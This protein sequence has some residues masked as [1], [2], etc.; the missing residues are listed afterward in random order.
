MV[1]QRHGMLQTSGL[2]LE[3]RDT[4]PAPAPPPTTAGAVGQLA[5]ASSSTLATRARP[6]ANDAEASHGAS[7]TQH[8][9]D[10]RL[11][12]QHEFAFARRAVTVA[13]AE[14]TQKE[15][16][17]GFRAVSWQALTKPGA[18]TSFRKDVGE[19]QLQL[20]PIVTVLISQACSGAGSGG[21]GGGGGASPAG[22]VQER[23]PQ[24]APTGLSFGLWC[25]T[26]RLQLNMGGQST[27]CW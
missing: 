26:T 17:L 25:A 20:S 16:P 22:T 24:S 21:G 13:P 4:G 5:A 12:H 10:R 1:T 11:S 7:T 15:S 2:A 9:T 23:F 14:E 8:F 18:A 3:T 6:R 27:P 19:L